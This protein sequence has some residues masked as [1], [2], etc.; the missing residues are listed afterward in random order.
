MPCKFS[1]WLDS[2]ERSN[3]APVVVEDDGAEVVGS[4]AEPADGSS[5]GY[6][7]GISEARLES[8]SV[9]LAMYAPATT[10]CWDPY[11]C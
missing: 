11:A 1:A 7:P 5:L 6:A 10:Y 9:D 4:Y 2:A 3:G 8:V